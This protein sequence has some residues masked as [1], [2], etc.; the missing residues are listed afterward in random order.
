ML[1]L[2]ISLLILS[3]TIALIL[4]FSAL[5]RKNEPIAT[6]F[7]VAM[8]SAGL[9]SF[10]FIVEALSATL[11]EKIFWAN[12]QFI[13]INIL[14][15]AWLMLIFYYTGRPRWV[16]R[17]LPILSLMPLAAML[18][19]WSNPYHHL[20]RVSPS[21]EVINQSF[22][23][24][25]NDYGTLLYTLFIPYHSILF[26]IA[27]ITLVQF[28][29]ESTELYRPQ[30]LILL[31]GSLLPLLTSTLYL[32][33]ITPIPNFNFTPIV[34]SF[35]G[36]L[37]SWSIFSFHFLS[38]TPLAKD[39]VFK[40]IQVG[41]IVLDKEGRITD[42]NSAAEEIVGRFSE[43]R[44][45][46]PIIKILPIFTPF[47]NLPS[48]EQTE[49][50]LEKN[51]KKEYY[52]T[53]ISLVLDKYKHILGRVITLN[54]IS[55]RVK[56]YKQVKATS[57]RDFLTGALNRR[58]FSEKGEYEI[59]RALRYKKH[60]SIIMIDIDNFKS[61]NDEMGHK[62]GD[63]AL[64]LVTNLCYQQMRSVDSIARYGGDEFVILLPETIA[65]DAFSFAQ[66]VHRDIIEKK[67]FTETGKIYSLSVSMGV[68]DISESHTLE[69]LLHQAD[70]ALYEAKRKGKGQVVLN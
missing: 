42:S 7:A 21:L 51:G 27:L 46:V 35:S 20:F 70:Q 18:V 3:G 32:L 45:G 52:D 13:G 14:P 49:M 54:N 24:L 55:E 50:V 1:W 64:A 60:L 19:I 53:R 8:F 25:N 22:S 57:M 33:G 69:S 9:W 17:K 43:H 30:G 56:L 62:Y 68:A 29:L 28:W 44:V 26:A 31:I 61:I 48:D 65:K 66:R 2:I 23:V 4:G 12:I 47:I 16:V 58:A 39:V 34:F 36:V 37:I 63:K 5:Q 10:G 15:L 6:A 40:T 38:I 59:T 41:I 67:I 11:Q